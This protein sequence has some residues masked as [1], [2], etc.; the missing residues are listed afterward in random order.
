M[1]DRTVLLQGLSQVTLYT[2]LSVGSTLLWPVTG[3]VAGSSV[4]GYVV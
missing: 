2:S 3:V 4:T 1:F